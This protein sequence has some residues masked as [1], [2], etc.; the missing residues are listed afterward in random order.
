MFKKASILFWLAVASQAFVSNVLAGTLTYD[1]IDY[2]A[3][4]ADLV[5]S[6]TDTI[7]GTII[8]DGTI[9]P[10]M[11][12]DIIGGTFT[13]TNPVYGSFSISSTDIY[14]IKNLDASAT[15]LT[16][17]RPQAAGT[18]AFDLV[19]STIFLPQDIQPALSYARFYNSVLYDDIF[20]AGDDSN[21]AFEFRDSQTTS[22]P[23]SISLS[24]TEPWVIATAATVPE[25]ATLT[26]LGAALLGHGVVY[27]RWRGAKA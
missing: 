1:V 22:G 16:L 27:L 9:G 26:L 3:L 10:L 11:A 15:A 2:P 8:T 13:I 12:S 17:P 5:T 21:T 20:Y 4:E 23:P 7:S 14:L 24:G 6:G 18:N 19:S 25:P